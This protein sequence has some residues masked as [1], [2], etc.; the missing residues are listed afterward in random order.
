VIE[1]RG[2]RIVELEQIGTP[3][4]AGRRSATIAR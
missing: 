1:I 2:N 4:P 3:F